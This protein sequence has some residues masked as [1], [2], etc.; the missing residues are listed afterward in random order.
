MKRIG[1]IVAVIVFAAAAFG[2]GM[3]LG[4]SGAGAP[5]AAGPGAF[6]AGG[7]GGS[8]GPMADLTDE[9]RA[10][11]ES[12][13]EEERQAF[14]Q[15]KMGG[16]APGGPARGGQLSG[17]VLEMTTDTITV[18]LQNGSQTFYYDADTTIAY[19]KGAADLAAG[20]K[21]LVIAEPAA[22]GVTNAT[23]IVVEK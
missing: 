18:K 4:R 22:D 17:E 11:I 6:A 15:E 8:G 12:M 7:P 3:L 19:E 5:S 23:A 9:E 2:G 14:F 1:I 10:E 13:T 16:A 20:S 21:V